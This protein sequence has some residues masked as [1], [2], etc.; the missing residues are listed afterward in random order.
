VTWVATAFVRPSRWLRGQPSLPASA[1]CVRLAGSVGWQPRR[2]GALRAACWAHRDRVDEHVACGLG[3]MRHA[4]CRRH[5]CSETPIPPT[6]TDDG[7]DIAGCARRRLH[8]ER[9]P[10]GGFA[11]VC[12]IATTWPDSPCGRP[13]CPRHWSAPAPAVW[14][15]PGPRL[16]QQG[17]VHLLIDLK[18]D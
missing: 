5:C 13:G 1:S 2:A 12:M 14:L 16:G 17:G 18:R 10:S 4:A 15:R 3:A 11:R 7:H 8:G 9:L 6:K